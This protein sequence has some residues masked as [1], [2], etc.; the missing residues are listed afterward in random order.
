MTV[1]IKQT[2]MDFILRNELTFD[3]IIWLSEPESQEYDLA[4]PEKNQSQTKKSRTGRTSPGPD[5]TQSTGSSS[6][7]LSVWNLGY[8]LKRLLQGDRCGVLVLDNAERIVTMSA[9]KGSEDRVYFLSQILLLPQLL[10]LN[11]SI[12]IVS[13]SLLLEYSRK[14]RFLQAS[15]ELWLNH[16]SLHFERHRT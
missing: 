10:E 11:L 12:I 1:C 16:I 4:F 9:S 7:S 8:D 3:I 5:I 6:I 15:S 2:R 13:K 14:Y